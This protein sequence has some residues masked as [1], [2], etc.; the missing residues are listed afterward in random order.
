MRKTVK[1]LMHITQKSAFLIR[2]KRGLV[3]DKQNAAHCF[4]SFF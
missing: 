4:Q 3:H 1:A 2:K